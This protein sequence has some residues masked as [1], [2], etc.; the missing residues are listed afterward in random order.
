[1]KSMLIHD[2]QAWQPLDLSTFMSLT[3][4]KENSSRVENMVVYNFPTL[5]LFCSFWLL[6][7]HFGYS[8]MLVLC[9]VSMCMLQKLFYVELFAGTFM[10]L[11]LAGI[12]FFNVF[13]FWHHIS[14]STISL[15]HKIANLYLR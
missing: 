5:F 10:A 8:S 11:L 15:T 1:M 7:S 2:L 9:E 14:I 6:L 13:K 12:I 4:L 3:P